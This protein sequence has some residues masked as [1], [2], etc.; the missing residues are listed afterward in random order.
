VK[1]AALNPLTVVSADGMV[2]DSALASGAEWM[3]PDAL[4]QRCKMAEKQCADRVAR[5]FVRK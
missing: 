4:D 2:R 1:Y 5:L 3:S